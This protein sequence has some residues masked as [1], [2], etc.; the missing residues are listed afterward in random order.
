[1]NLSRSGILPGGSLRPHR[2]FT[3]VE[4]LV[5]IAIIGTLVGLLLPA[6]QAARE[7]ARRS[8][9]INNIKQL[10]LGLLNFHD[11]RGAFPGATLGDFRWTCGPKALGPLVMILPYIEETVR[12]NKFDLTKDFNDPVNTAAAGGTMP[13]LTF[14]CP[15]YGEKKSGS[16]YQYCSGGSFTTGVTCYLGVRGS[17]HDYSVAST[18]GVFG[19]LLTGNGFYSGQ[20]YANPATTKIKDITDGTSKTFIYGE[21]RPDSQI[22]VGQSPTIDPDSRWSPWS[23]GHV[24]EGSGSTKT[25]MYSPNQVAG[26]TH[27]NQWAT[28]SFS[29]QHTGGLHMVRADASAGFV[30]DNIDITIWRNLATIAGGETNTRFE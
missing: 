28:H 25:M 2:G 4:L 21:F 26:F 11:A 13:P 18:R 6:V 8:A 1:M 27:Y 30:S 22:V 19:L 5:V 23:L 12:Y 7:S 17:A 15:S 9:C 10:G 14:L 16:A 29:S 3:L 20:P 24:L